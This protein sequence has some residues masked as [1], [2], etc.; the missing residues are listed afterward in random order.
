MSRSITTILIAVLVGVNIAGAFLY[1]RL[2]VTA[3]RRYSISA[4]TKRIVSQLD[5]PLEVTGYFST[6]LPPDL[7]ETA[8]YVHDM[9]AELHAAHSGVRLK[10]VDPAKNDDAEK[11]A[12]EAG[13]PEVEMQVLDRDQYKVQRG[14]FGIA[15]AYDGKHESIPLVS[16]VDNLE[17]EL[18]TLIRKLSSA[19]QKKVGVV[20]GHGEHSTVA[21]PPQYAS[22][23]GLGGDYTAL[24]KAL[25]A[26]YDVVPVDLD[27]EHSLD[28]VATLIIA[29]PKQPYTERQLYD[30]DQF[31][32]RGGH[33]LVLADRVTVG[34][35]LE[36]AALDPKLND[37]LEAYGVTVH[38]DLLIDA[39]HESVAFNS[40]YV[41]YILPYPLWPRLTAAGFDA[42]HP[43]MSKLRSL[44]FPWASTL[45]IDPKDGVRYA[46]LA[47]STKASFVQTDPFD[48]SPNQQF[49]PAD[50]Q[51]RPMI[52]EI[53]GTLP[54]AFAGKKPPAA[55][56]QKG[57]SAPRAVDA[58]A[59]AVSSG[60]PRIIVVGDSDFISD[61]YL[62][63]F[64]DNL[65]FAQNAI[66]YLT[67]GDELIG[68]RAKSLTARPLDAPS[69]T[70][71][72]VMKYGTAV[73]I[74]L[75]IVAAGLLRYRSRRSAA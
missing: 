25:A 9:L 5:K 50:Q 4:S 31:I 20:T 75:L 46:T 68:I 1:Y 54:S 64:P 70:A 17:Y 36:A 22:I 42:A 34:D 52:V 12:Q 56:V 67:L 44:S 60:D 38:D 41:Q 73:A 59:A 18:V 2:D 62:Q 3:E 14:Y 49:A 29:G 24:G 61:T 11:A 53:S 13:I 33:L 48:L 65:S 55:A 66:D 6:E 71:K 72:N 15:L 69:E 57:A 47:A 63:R 10:F 26:T 58:A 7:Q 32:M 8:Q 23:A 27:A 39:S 28:G 30:I 43:V 51:S 35:G 16:Q 21:V 74:P 40:G 45:G 19:E 37:L